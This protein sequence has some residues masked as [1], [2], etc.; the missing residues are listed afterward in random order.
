MTW[1]KLMWSNYY[2]QLFA[3]AVVSFIILIVTY[4]DSYSIVGFY[5]ALS[6]PI[7]M[8]AI[9]GYFGFYK[10]WQEQKPKK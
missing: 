10:F 6:I 3:V 4:N 8:M 2:I 9:I 7:M 1:F 5:V